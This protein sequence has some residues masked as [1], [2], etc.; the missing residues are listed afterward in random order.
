MKHR[1]LTWA[2]VAAVLLVPVAHAQEN[3][4]ELDFDGPIPTATEGG[5]CSIVNLQGPV[6]AGFLSWTTPGGGLAVWYDPNGTGGAGDPGCGSGS[7]DFA[8]NNFLV[9]DIF[10]TLGDEAAFGTGTGIADFTYSL[11]IH[12]ANTPGDPCTE[13]GAVLWDSGP[14]VFNGS[15]AGINGVTIP[16][17]F[18]VSGPF[19]VQWNII[20]SS[21]GTETFTPLWDNVARPVCLQWVTQDAGA[22]YTDF[23]TFFTGGD[24]GWV[25]MT[26]NGDCV[27]AGPM[28]STIDVP[29]LNWVG[30]AALLLALTAAGIFILKRRFV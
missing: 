6:A 9:N 16:V 22:M 25:D 11:V 29:T 3:P 4:V 5:S 23:T 15:G 28:Q 26:V 24:T 8:D 27:A 13:P 21:V 14:L 20:S 19:F 18:E 7:C 2:A 10:W 1:V 30:I 12:D 17:N